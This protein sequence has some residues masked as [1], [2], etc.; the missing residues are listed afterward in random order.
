MSWADT[1]G[2]V[3]ASV[4]ASGGAV[5]LINAFANRKKVKVDAVDQLSDTALEQVR[6]ALEQVALA[7]QDAADARRS[8][9]QAWAE[10]AEARREA[11]AVAAHL[12]RL[13]SEILS[14]VATIE[15]LRTLVSP[16][17]QNGYYGRH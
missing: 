15:H 10:A 1:A 5:A 6:S 2:T 11:M 7:R 9:T 12:R 3:V 8:A 4:L 16:G 17:T 13:T 14:P